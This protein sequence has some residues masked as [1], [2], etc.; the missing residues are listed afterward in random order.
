MEIGPVDNSKIVVPDIKEK[1]VK[2]KEGLEQQPRQDRVEI[3]EEGRKRLAELA[4]NFIKQVN[5]NQK[6]HS[7]KIER[8]KAK[9][10]SGFYDTPE[11]KEKIA[12][13]LSDDIIN[14]LNQSE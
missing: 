2:E 14:D 11:V 6:A 5:E 12:D 8:I 10:N 3:S 13:K 9:V 7:D 4:D 1:T